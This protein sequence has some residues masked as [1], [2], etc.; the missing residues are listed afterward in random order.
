MKL[1]TSLVAFVLTALPVAAQSVTLP[2]QL[3]VEAGG[4][5]HVKPIKIDGGAV[6]WRLDQDLEEI[7]PESLF[8]PEIAKAF[9]GK[10]VKGPVGK[11]KVEAWNAKGEIA[12]DIATTWVVIG[13]PGP[14]PIPD[15]PPTAHPKS[16]TFLVIGATLKTAAV[17]ENTGFRTWLKSKSIDVYG[18]VTK[19]QQDANPKF[20]GIPSP[21]IV[22]Q[23]RANNVI[24]HAPL[25]DITDAMEF[26]TKH[27]EK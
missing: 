16:L 14:T 24:A 2:V 18:I 6:K 25:T 7:P 5:L 1:L 22:L 21:S 20:A 10:I 3:K 12:S 11:Y 4:W 26:V 13:K 8:P 27:L 9:I 23:D 15:P 17:T 19:A